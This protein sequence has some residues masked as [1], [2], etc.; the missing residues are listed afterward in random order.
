[1]A[2][3]RFY[4]V[5]LLML[6]TGAGRGQDAENP[7]GLYDRPVL[8]VEQG[9]HTR[10]IWSASADREARWVVTGSED[11]TIRIWSLADGRLDRTIRLPTGPGNIG[12]AHRVAI[13]P[14]GALIAAG[15][16]TR[17]E[18]D[19]EQIYLFDRSNG[20]LLQRIEGVSNAVF[21]V[22]FS[23]DGSRLAALVGGDGVRVYAKET[24]WG[25]IAR[26]EDYGEPGY[27]VDFAPDGRLATT[28]FDGKLRLYS[29]GL[30]GR[31]HPTVTVVRQAANVPI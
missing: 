15:G 30:T 9:T 27:G 18:I 24:A 5:L 29:A 22:V 20:K 12:L 3:I 26:D 23:P 8:A 4:L 17:G 10:R 25:E 6:W 1:M 21:A 31:V 11:K 7:P 2:R 19:Q 28:S 14:D 13:S 16:L